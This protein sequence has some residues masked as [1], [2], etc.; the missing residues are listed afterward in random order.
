M[1]IVWI[2]VEMVAFHGFFVAVFVN[3]SGSWSVPR[4]T[5]EYVACFSAEMPHCGVACTNVVVLF[6]TSCVCPMAW[7]ERG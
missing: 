7:T 2:G 1:I 6:T 5:Y 4:G 3:E